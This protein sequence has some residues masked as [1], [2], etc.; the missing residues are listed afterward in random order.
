[1]GAVHRPILPSSLVLDTRGWVGEIRRNGLARS[2]LPSSFSRTA[3]RPGNPS[4]RSV[5]ALGP[6]SLEGSAAAPARP[7]IPRESLQGEPRGGPRS[8]RAPGPGHADD[9]GDPGRSSRGGA[10]RRRARDIQGLGQRKESPP[11]IG[12]REAHR[13]LAPAAGDREAR[14]DR[15]LLLDPSPE[16]I[17]FRRAHRSGRYRAISNGKLISRRSNGRRRKVTYHWRQD[18]THPAYLISL[19]V[20]KFVELKDRAGQVP[21]HGYVPRG[22]EAE[23]RELFRKTPAMIAAFS[24]VFGYP[25]PYPKYAQSTVFDFTFGGMENT[26]ATTLTVRALQTPE[27]AIDQTYETLISHELAHQW[28]GDLVTCRDWSEG[29]L[30]EGFATYSEVVFWEAEHGRDEADFARLEQ[31]CSYLVED[32]GDYRRPLVETA[33][34]YPSEIFDRHLYEKGACVVH[35]LR[36]TLGDAVWRRGLKRYLERHAFGGVETGDLKRAC[37]EVSGRNLTWFFDQWAHQGGHPELKVA[38]EWDANARALLLTIEQVQE[39]DSV[40]PA[41]FHIPMVLELKVGDRRLRLP[42]EAKQRKETIRIP[43]PQKPRYVALDPEH[44]MMKLMEFPRSEEELLYGLQ[45]SSFSLERVRC[46]RELATRGDPPVVEALFRAARG[47]RFWGVRIAALASLGEI[48]ARRA[49]MADRI[50]ELGKGQ[51]PRVRRAVAWALG[52][53]GGEEAIRHLRKMVSTDPSK[54]TAGMALLGIARSKREE[55]FDLLRAELARESHRDILRQ[56]IFDGFV[57]L[58]DPRAVPILLDYTRPEHRN[59]A[60]EAATKALGKLGI[61][62]E[63]VESRLIELLRDPWF[64]VRSAAARSL[65]KLKAPRAE[66]AIREALQ[67][68]PMDTVQSAFEGALDDLKAPR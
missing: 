54:F 9:R 33:Y 28:W 5:S 24:K 46:A 56:H 3:R 8:A 14:H 37:E 35:M 26:G 47:D 29:W 34:R 1:M 27:E 36:A 62:D 17:L 59:E 66:G 23:G 15:R 65:A 41:V 61:L 48:G 39:P 45:E 44:D 18:T 68:E 58:K 57:I 30:N 42:I 49:G 12:S 55:A 7:R 63:K 67:G 32:N 25:Y 60:R 16:G 13:H 52:W 10:G 2:Y 20:G 50:A 4:L 21:L 11:R 19:V 40:T 6:E 43:L 22:R 31:M 38:R 51:K 53:M 64:R